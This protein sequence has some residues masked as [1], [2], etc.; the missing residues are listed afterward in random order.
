M[1]KVK[2]VKE[3]A[4]QT[5]SFWMAGIITRILVRGEYTLIR[6]DLL[7][8]ITFFLGYLFMSWYRFK[9]GPEM[10]PLVSENEGE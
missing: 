2:L 9:N 8:P 3:T 5:M 1:D 10:G 4:I 7:F 6:G